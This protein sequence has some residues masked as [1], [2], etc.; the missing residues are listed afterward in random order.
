M[1]HH[2][3]VYTSAYT[4]VYT[5]AYVSLQDPSPTG[6]LDSLQR[7]LGIALTQ[8]SPE[9]TVRVRFPE[10][11]HLLIID[12]CSVSP[13]FIE[14]CGG[15]RPLFQNPLLALVPP[16]AEDHLVSLYAAGVDECIIKPVDVALMAAKAKSWLRWATDNDAD[17]QAR[18]SP[19]FPDVREARSKPEPKYRL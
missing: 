9:Q 3:A 13:E 10:H 16:T 18:P 6:W 7:K 15:I 8:L 19:L 5:I 12:G 4:S 17:A 1:N 2:T 11:C 14:F